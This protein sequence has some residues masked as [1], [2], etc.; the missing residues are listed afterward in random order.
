VISTVDRRDEAGRL[1]LLN[2]SPD[3]GGNRRV[4]PG[5][6]VGKLHIGFITFSTKYQTVN[7]TFDQATGA[8]Q[9][10]TGNVWPR[11][12]VPKNQFHRHCTAIRLLLSSA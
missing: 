7:V 2:R 6:F 3:V 8:R 4:K 11:L 10:M 5:S 9:P 12:A 1:Q